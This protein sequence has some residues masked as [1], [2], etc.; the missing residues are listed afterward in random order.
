M[1][2]ER[3]IV[4]HS[5]DQSQQV[6]VDEPQPLPTPTQADGD[7]TD[8]VGA[9]V[10][11][12]RT[13]HPPKL[14]QTQALQRAGYADTDPPEIKELKSELEVLN[15][16][17]LESYFDLIERN[18]TGWAAPDGIL[19]RHDL[20]CAANDT[21]IDAN[22]R[23][24]ASKLL[25]SRMFTLIA[26]ADGNISREELV[27][28][29]K[30]VQAQLDGKT[31][32]NG[33]LPEPA[34]QQLGTLTSTASALTATQQAATGDRALERLGNAIDTLQQRLAQLA[35]EASD[36]PEDAA[37]KQAEIAKL[38]GQLQ[39]LLNLQTTISTML[40][41]VA[42]MWSDISSNALRNIH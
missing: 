41:N 15:K 29:R 14:T 24:L 39:V 28:Y 35:S 2:S 3:T 22:A 13:A 36:K 26:G 9:H 17:D 18:F 25:N 19:S 37:K 5:P 34:M 32:S 21:T 31:V 10:D 4:T 40:S 42:K 8:V 16:L 30:Q 7:S 1:R 6:G 11:P 38:N 33:A 27:A 23:E 12:K 20:E